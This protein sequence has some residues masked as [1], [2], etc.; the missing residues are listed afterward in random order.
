MVAGGLLA[1]AVDDTTALDYLPPAWNIAWAGS[2]RAG[3]GRSY[4]ALLEYATFLSYVPAVLW[5]AW[6]KQRAPAVRLVSRRRASPR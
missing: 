4:P 1:L 2:D 5:A 3:G 6:R